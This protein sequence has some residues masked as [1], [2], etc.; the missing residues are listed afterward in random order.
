MGAALDRQGIAVR[1]G[2]H[3]AQPVLRH[4]GCESVVRASLAL[5]NTK[6]DVDRL[7]DALV[8]LQK[9]GPGFQRSPF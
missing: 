3:C 1:A 6:Q 9:R 4:F 7:A 5:Y 2:H 8:Q